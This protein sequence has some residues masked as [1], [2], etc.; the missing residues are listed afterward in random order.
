MKHYSND[1]APLLH[2]QKLTSPIMHCIAL[3]NLYEPMKQLISS[4]DKLKI[5]D[6]GWGYGYMS[7]LL[8]K[9]TLKISKSAD[10]SIAGFDLHPEF[11]TKAYSALDQLLINKSIFKYDATNILDPSFHPLQKY[12]LIYSGWAFSASKMNSVLDKML[13]DSL[14][15]LIAP[16]VSEASSE[17]DYLLFRYH[18][19]S[20][21]FMLLFWESGCAGLPDICV[22]VIMGFNSKYGKSQAHWLGIQFINL[23]PQLKILLIQLEI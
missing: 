4:T 13:D 5:A 22:R 11:Q 20:W 7:V 15:Y 8:Y 16:Q 1:P 10:I 18:S 2:S 21:M 12:N 14:S 3:E 9:L 23:S 6:I 17:Q 19:N